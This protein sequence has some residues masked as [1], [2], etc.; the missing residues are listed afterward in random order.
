MDAA[1]KFVLSTRMVLG[2]I[3]GWYYWDSKRMIP[4]SVCVLWAKSLQIGPGE[5]EDTLSLLFSHFPRESSFMY[6][7]LSSLFF[8]YP[9][10]TT[11]QK[12][13]PILSPVCRKKTNANRII[14]TFTL[15]HGVL[16]WGFQYLLNFL[17]LKL[18]FKKLI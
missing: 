15:S 12:I 14:S 13:R 7:W 6:T 8:L 4:L 16:S 11:I 2:S 10:Q 18:Q 17:F 1:S 5:T 3:M 9:L